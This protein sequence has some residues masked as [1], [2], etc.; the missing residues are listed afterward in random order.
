MRGNRIIAGALTLAALSVSGSSWAAR[1]EATT[2]DQLGVARATAWVDV[3]DGEAAAGHQLDV[4]PPASGEPGGG[5]PAPPP[6][7][8]TPFVQALVEGLIGAPADPDAWYIPPVEAPTVDAGPHLPDLVPLPAWAVYVDETNVATTAGDFAFATVTG[9]DP[10]AGSK[11]ALRFGVTIANR[12]HHS[13]EVVGTPQPTG[14]QEDPVRVDA[15]QC[16]RFAGARLAGGERTC[17]EYKPVGSLMFHVQHGH[18]HIDGFA[19]YRLLRD[20]GGRP[21][22][23]P[24]GLLTQSEKVGFCMGDT[25]WLGEGALVVDSGWYRE[26]RHTAPHV[27]VTLRQGVSPAWGDSYG[28]DL[29]GQHLVIED[30]ADGVYWIAVT[31]NPANVPGA[32]SL[33]ETNRANNVSYR[34]V[35]L[36]KGGTEVKV[37]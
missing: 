5:P 33:F 17:V 26:C 37:F 3:R 29:P 7:M 35:E 8:F 4:R 1:H 22:E 34:K 15:R 32:V 18:F 10:F 19:Q 20:A 36:L 25:D 27:P 12:G 21:D 13:L 2:G 9:E 28:P 6:T 31:V 24:G 30:L 11:K 16:V 23:G 14:D